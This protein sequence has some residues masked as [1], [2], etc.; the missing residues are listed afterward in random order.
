VSQLESRL[1]DRAVP[2]IPLQLSDGRRLHLSDLW[3]ERPL[4]VTFFYRRCTGICTPFLEGVRDATRRSGGLGSDYRVLALSFDDADSAEDVEA[5]AAALGL[6]GS[7]GWDFAV[8][9]R[10]AL[11]RITGALDFWYRYDPARRQIEHNAMIVGIDGGRVVRAL[12]AGGGEGGR[13][14]ELVWE[15]RGSFIPFYAVPGQTPLSCF[16]FD[17][18]TGEAR[19]DWGMLLLLLPALAALIAALGVFSLGGRLRR[20]RPDIDAAKAWITSHH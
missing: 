13:M 5:Q 3:R 14:R 8:T 20:S 19:L 9:D 18:A 6:L 7:P 15:L 1:I 16:T 10:E 17:A 11:G 12:V 4:L 2:D